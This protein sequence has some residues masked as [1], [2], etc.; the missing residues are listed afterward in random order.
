MSEQK[1]THL[2]IWLTASLIANALLVGLLIGGGLANRGF[3]PPQQGG[4]EY[5][6]A[7]GIDQAIPQSEREAVRRAFRQAFRRAHG[8]SREPRRELHR[9]RADLGRILAAEPYDREAVIAAFARIR[10]ADQ[11]A[12]AGFH[13]ELATVLEGLSVEQRLAISRDLDRPGRARYQRRTPRHPR[14][15][16]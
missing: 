4:G 9:A 14:P 5:T 10:G 6:L 12:K 15:E 13:E 7:R 2:P 8:D 1:S 3:P 16:E 11:Q